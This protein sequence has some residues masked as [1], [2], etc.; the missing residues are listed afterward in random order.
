MADAEGIDYNQ[1]GGGRATAH[2]RAVGSPLPRGGVHRSAYADMD[3]N[4]DPLGPATPGRSLVSSSAPPEPSESSG[5]QR[6]LN[7]LRGA[8][9]FMQR[10]LPLLDGNIVGAVA[11]VLAHQSQ[12]PAPPVSL[13]PVQESI[14]ELQLQ[15][16]ELQDR[17]GEQNISIQRV[18][19]QLQMVR[20][21]TDRNTLEQ[22]EL[23]EDLKAVGH[24]MNMIALIALGLLAV[25]VV[26]NLVLYLHIQR[27][28]P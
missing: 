24:K 14:S 18:E 9:P 21:A 16:R 15:H 19:D 2:P 17:V 26:L 27:V 28:L 6:A 13:A 4:S 11:G 25:S 5:V 22:Q 12:K 23:M 1:E 8:V 10:L 20:E 7:A 3:Q